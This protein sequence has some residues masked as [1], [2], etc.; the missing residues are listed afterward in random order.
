MEFQTKDSGKRLMYKTGMVRDTD[1]NKPR[2]DLVWLPM[3]TRWAELYTRGAVKYGDN[4][5]QKAKTKEE[6]IRFRASAWRHFVQYMAG[7]TDE[8]HGAAVFF[9]IAA[10]EYTKQRLHEQI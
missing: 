10:A 8:D 6:L 3:L 1:E 9:N 4:N 7:D 2:Y 5:W